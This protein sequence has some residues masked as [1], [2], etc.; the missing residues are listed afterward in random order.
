MPELRSILAAPP[1]GAE[2]LLTLLN[3]Y[4]PQEK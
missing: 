2:H 1:R 3:R 4:A